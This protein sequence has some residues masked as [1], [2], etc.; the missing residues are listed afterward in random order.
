MT[1]EELKKDPN[2]E[3]IKRVAFAINV[4]ADDGYTMIDKVTEDDYGY[5]CVVDG[6]VDFYALAKAAIDAFAG[7]ALTK[8]VSNQCINT[9]A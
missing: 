9:L 3:L 7:V 4:A 1:I 6:Q 8:E 2:Y 5:Y